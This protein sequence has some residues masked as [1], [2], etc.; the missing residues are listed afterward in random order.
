MDNANI[1]SVW[2]FYMEWSVTWLNI[3]VKHLL[4]LIKFNRIQQ[5]TSLMKQK[6]PY[7]RTTILVIFLF[8][9]TKLNRT[10]KIFI[11]LM[12]TTKH[13]LIKT[14]YEYKLDL[15]AIFL[16]SMQNNKQKTPQKTRSIG[17]NFKWQKL[18]MFDSKAMK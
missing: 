10:C 18:W 9:S 1:F 4:F 3:N 8:N 6:M 5:L 17:F 15:L 2:F 12:C 16:H 14:W 7:N 11:F 13:F